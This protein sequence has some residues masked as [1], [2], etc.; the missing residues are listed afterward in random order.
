MLFRVP[1]STVC[2]PSEHRSV[3]R[4]PARGPSCFLLAASDCSQTVY[5]KATSF[6]R[7]DFVG[8]CRP[9]NSPVWASELVRLLLCPNDATVGPGALGIFLCT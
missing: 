6:L 8:Q 1:I 3:E 4:K 2:E 7:L 9:E 5:I